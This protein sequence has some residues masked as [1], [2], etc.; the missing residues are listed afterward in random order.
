MISPSAGWNGE[1]HALG[2]V[3][4]EAS[5]SAGVNYVGYLTAHL[6]VGEAARNMAEA[7]S[8]A[9]TPVSALDISEL[10]QS[11]RG[12]YD[13]VDRLK[14]GKIYPTTILHV[15]AD[16]LPFVLSKLP[17]DYADTLK[18]GVWAWESSEFP[19]EWC[20]RF[21]LLDEVWVCSGFIAAA[22]AEKATIPVFT[23]PYVFNPPNV[24]AD[25]SW[26]RRKVP[27][28]RQDEF[29]F[30]FQFDTLSI[31]YR[32]NPQGAI[33]A[34]MQA[35]SPDMPVRLLV[36]TING[37]KSAGLI[38][39]L[40]ELASGARVTIWDE[41]LSNEARFKLLASVDS[42]VSLHR[43]EGFGMSIAE[44][45]L[46][47]KPVIVTGWSGN[48]DFVTA[49]SA[50]L[51]SY[52][53]QKL[54][55]SFGPY[56]QGTIWAEPSI[57]DAAA[58][59]R[60]VYEDVGYRTALGEN[61]ARLIRDRLNPATIGRLARERLKLVSPSASRQAAA[62]LV[63]SNQLQMV[64]CLTRDALR[65]P[66]FYTKRIPTALRVLRAQ[67]LRSMLRISMDAAAVQFGA[68][69]RGDGSRA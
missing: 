53:L 49:D 63:A 29:V 41:A 38:A 61:A 65:R 64:G 18:I 52:T 45:M 54:P 17:P 36:K 8:R 25:R 20:D 13:I 5:A 66:S 56:R 24:A 69:R 34:F 1:T 2:D 26:L 47:K 15:N 55:Q 40:N 9:G 7:L 58:W 44:A 16:Q 62:P 23:L 21:D 68:A 30:L 22:V 57:E 33:R 59:M 27:D 31:P 35:F 42:F 11:P 12:R 51:V 50:A 48:A 6:G 10:S 4:A 28:L 32:K 46:L 39:E 43:A 67:G 60:R 14:T 3:F 37:G 19:D